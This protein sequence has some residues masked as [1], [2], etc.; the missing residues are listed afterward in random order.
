MFT[1]DTIIDS[2]VKANKQIV[3]KMV[4]DTNS[5]SAI[6]QLI[7]TQAQCARETAIALTIVGKTLTDGATD[8]LRKVINKDC[9]EAFKAFQKV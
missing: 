6:N 9:F 2:V 5:A 1:M 3:E 8:S 4:K 7:D